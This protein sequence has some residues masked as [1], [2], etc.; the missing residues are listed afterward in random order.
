MF[1]Y[2]NYFYLGQLPRLTEIRKQKFD[3]GSTENGSI[4]CMNNY[5]LLLS[6]LDMKLLML[7][8]LI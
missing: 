8:L 3:N 1:L 6:K 4:T 5:Q 7:H 2:Q